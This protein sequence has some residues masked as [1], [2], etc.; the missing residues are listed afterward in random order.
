MSPRV[1]GSRRTAGDRQKGAFLPLSCRAFIVGHQ[2]TIQKT[3]L[4]IWFG[5]AH[6]RTSCCAPSLICFRD[7]FGRRPL[8]CCWRRAF[9]LKPGLRRARPRSR[10]W[11]SAISTRSARRTVAAVWPGSPVWSPQSGRNRRMS[12]WRL[13]ETRSSPSLLSSFDHGRHMVDLLNTIAPDVFVPGNHEFDFGEA[14]FRARMAEAKVP[15]SRRTSGRR[16]VS[17]FPDFKIT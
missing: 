12:L 11:C 7:R 15:F 17:R 10:C 6:A 9:P 8:G 1:C 16:A 5:S 2:R 13:P 4:R 3:A 14:V